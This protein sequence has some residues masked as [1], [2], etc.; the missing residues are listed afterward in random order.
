MNNLSLNS[1]AAPQS[2]VG[3]TALPT[4]WTFYRYSGCATWS[5]GSWGP[6]LVV[7]GS[8]VFEASTWSRRIPSQGPSV[9]GISLLIRNIRRGPLRRS[10]CPHTGLHALLRPAR[11]HTESPLKG[12]TT[13]DTSDAAFPVVAR[14]AIVGGQP[15]V[16]LAP[17][18]AIAATVG[19]RSLV[20]LVPAA[21]TLAIAASGTFASSVPLGAIAAFG[22]QGWLAMSPMQLWAAV[23]FPISVSRIFLLCF[24]CLCLLPGSHF[25]AIYK[26]SE[27]RHASGVR[28]RLRPRR[29][30]HKSLFSSSTNRTG[31]TTDNRNFTFR[32]A[33]VRDS[34]AAFQVHHAYL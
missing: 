17:V 24:S 12:N 30:Y 10:L 4:P 27:G 7:R 25:P 8:L 3:S 11:N 29:Y 33:A 23:R 19:D 22:P 21:A 20:S 26:L 15:F 18:V 31:W 6:W 14:A 32:V 5:C 9:A 34:G 16:S 13:F 2:K 1:R 28:R